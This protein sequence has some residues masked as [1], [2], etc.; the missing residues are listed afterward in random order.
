[1]S[2]A[3]I[4]SSTY[5]LQF[6]A[7]FTFKDALGVLDYVEALGIGDVYASPFFQAA[8][9]STHGYDVADHNRLNPALGSP[10]D[11]R[12]W[13]SAL[14]ERKMGQLLDFV[15]NHMGIAQ[16]INQWWMEVLED[17]ISSPYARFFDINW[18]PAKEALAEK[19]L[20]PILG[21][22]YGKV[23]ESG[24][25]KIRYEGGGFFLRFYETGL[26]LR[27]AS[28]PGILRGALDRLE[29]APAAELQAIISLFAASPKAEQKLAA[30]KRL[31]D[32]YG[33]EQLV[34]QAIDH[35]LRGLEGEPGKPESF[36][37]MHAILEAQAYRI[38]YWRAAA[39]EINYRRF[40]DINTLAAIRVE[41]PEVFEAAH[42][43]VFQ[44]LSRGDV[45]G[46][47]ID[48]VDGL[49]NPKEYL[50]RLQERYAQLRG[51]PAGSNSLYL[52]VEK[53]LDL[54]R[55]QM[56]A[57]WPTH[58][59][60]GYE[61]ANQ[62]VHFFT[63][64]EAEKPMTTT[65]RRFAEMPE[66]FADLVYEKKKLMTQISLYSEVLE[67]GRILDELSEV[68]R[69]YRDFTRNALTSAVREVMACFPV[70]RTYATEQ[71]PMSAE[72]EKMV[73]RAISA[74]RRRN[75]LIEKAL[76]DFLRNVLLL[77]VP[78]T[79]SAEQREKH[80]R[81][82]MKFQQCS[83]PVMAKGL[84]DTTLYIYAR[85]IALNEVGGNP[86]QFGLDAAEFHRLNAE[87]L[88]R[89]PH[90]MLATSTHD[91]KRSE[92]VRMR[93]AAL[94][95][96]SATW[97]DAI[98]H[99]SRLNH[100]HRTSIG[101][102]LAPSPNEECLL[103]QTLL[104][105]WPLDPMSGEELAIYVE[106]IKQ[107][108]LK[109]VKEAKINS[110]WTEPHLEWENALSEF[111]ERILEKKNHAF[112]ARLEALAAQLAPLGAMNSL[113]QLVLKSTLPG[114]PDFYQG[115]EI[116]DFSL[117]DPDNRRPVDYEKRRQLL[118]VV[119]AMP[120]AG[121]L[122]Q[123]QT[124]GIK[125]FTVQ[126]LMRFRREHEDFFREADYQ[127]LTASGTFAR[128]VVGYVRQRGN[129]RLLVLVPRLSHALKGF[130]VGKKWEDTTVA[131]EGSGQWR[132]VLTGRPVSF[133]GNALWLA[134]A[135][136]ELPM[137]VFYQA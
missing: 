39:E 28:Y 108:M 12:A 38:S 58:G 109:A 116:W 121:L 96:M 1:M 104:G 9:E 98:R 56:P 81:F 54:T 130:P 69:N 23:L 84:E 114:V 49:W 18:N 45:T 95:E 97:H 34:A 11:F 36:D 135:L 24:E 105:T 5:R 92:D 20:L 10:E 100:K 68:H 94:S 125:I 85:H 124:G 61:F 16:S 76:F 78:E 77:R 72:D 44:L 48:H 41:I 14:R 63:D 70:Y 22:R 42:Q 129:E 82:V 40:F 112:R 122:G 73:L 33:R 132:N 75:P 102:E 55:E 53:I 6:H 27:P 93:L 50:I 137:A 71:E 43:F 101:E 7:G 32:L 83:G 13:C 80:I 119:G 31:Q 87:R 74:A 67:L 99:W 66:S 17:G 57:D 106:R 86:G 47:R 37:A 19:V 62:I 110:S 60:T 51:D 115:S 79:L 107:Y 4:P 15:P 118:R 46:L 111:I 134:Q 2:G 127:P 103:Y 113:S 25:L 89:F 117:V 88:K 29:G 35:A 126:R 90:S 133:S 128:H 65:Y 131:V 120:P 21:D 26:P 123:W 136:D 59:T 30:K 52:V 3:R 8:P 64:P 91:T